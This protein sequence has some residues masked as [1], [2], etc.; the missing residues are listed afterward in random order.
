MNHKKLI[1]SFAINL[2]LG[3]LALVALAA[4]AVSIFNFNIENFD[5]SFLIFAPITIFASPYLR[6]PLPRT[7]IYLSVSEVLVF[8][9]FLVYGI[10]A[11]VLVAGVESFF[12]SIAFRRQGIEISN[13]TILFNVTMSIVNIFVA[14]EAV[15]LIFSSPSKASANNSIAEFGAVLLCLALT[16]F[17][18]NWINISVFEIL[19]NKTP[20]KR[21]GK[22][23]LDSCFNAFVVYIAAALIAGVAVKA[24]SQF[25]I[26]LFV[27]GFAVFGVFYYTYRRY[28]DD[29][30]ATSAKA[31]Q[32]ERE[33][34]EQAERHIEELQHHIAEQD[35]IGRALRESKEKFR[36][37][38]FH[39]SLTDLPNRNLFM[40]T[41]SFSLEKLKHKP[42]FKFAILFL[43]INRFKTINDSLGHSM[44]DR[45]ILH[46]A[47]RLLTSV[48]EKDLAAR[49]SGDEFAFILNNINGIEDA[50]ELAKIIK[51]KI[52]APFTLNGRQVFTSFSIG[53]AMGN[54]GYEAAEDVLRDADIAMY[55]AKETKKDYVVFDKKMHASAVTL[56]QLE[57][58]L[59]TAVE[60][61]QLCM[62]YQPIVD[63][64]SMRLF[65]FE[66][67]IRWNHPQRGLVPP[68]E[69]IPVSEETGLIIPMTLWILRTSCRQMVK[70]QR[71][72]EANKNLVVSVN[73]SGKHFA[74]KDLVKQIKTIIDETEI[75]PRHLKLELTESAVM[76]NAEGV[77]LMLKQLRE[78]GIQLSIDDFGTGYSSLSY[79]HRF[80]INTLKV[81]RSF[82]STME[83]GSENGEIVRTVI[84]LAKTLGLNVIAEGIESIHQLHQLRI[85]GCEYGQGYLFSRPVPIEEAEKIIEDKSRW[86]NIIPNQNLLPKAQKPD[87]S[88]LRLAK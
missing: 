81:D 58:D 2:Y 77:I 43:D 87:V 54:A 31:E 22:F 29:V 56:L 59:R 79:L 38:A 24:Q 73:L 42:N 52:S 10:S 72:S 4:G 62:Y 15:I 65:G 67:L 44:G 68:S 84:A 53:I 80:P 85:L 83:D 27:L 18:V 7:K 63:L 5:L 82:V 61:D 37:A 76:E 49:F 30:K 12:T 64:D 75:D 13:R 28:V 21:S 14:A 32:S 47:K 78:L 26:I 23:L 17:L 35:R 48:R 51:E 74:Q 66:S 1:D 41:L 3:L 69:F 34:A 9:I 46:V 36:H 6:I 55:N 25:N 16:Q 19:R 40:E 8:Y 71:K 33:R 45:L 70:W 88:R 39:D 11:A 86:Q 50:I 20:L 60:R 57:T